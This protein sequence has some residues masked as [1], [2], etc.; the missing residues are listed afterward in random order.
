MK[1]P[2]RKKRKRGWLRMTAAALF[3]SL[4]FARTS[5]AGEPGWVQENDGWHYY[6]WDGTE[7]TG[8]LELGGLYYFLSDNGVCLTDAMTPD[9]Y[10]VDGNGAW[11]QREKSIL[12][13]RMTAPEQ[14]CPADVPLNEGGAAASL[15]GLIRRSFGGARLLRVSDTAIEYVSAGGADGQTKSG[16]EMVLAGLYREA[17]NGRYRLDLRMSLDAGAS[18][19]KT[20][21][22]FDYGVFQA[23][24]YQFSSSPEVLGAAVCSAWNGD[25]QWNINRQSPAEA[26]DSQVLYAAGDGFGR[27]YITPRSVQ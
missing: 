25:N 19:K 1:A 26:G 4:A 23:L 24:L 3:L 20:A 14:F 9:G 21:A 13:V 18:G 12:G 8:W 11:Y 10:Y 6:L 15:S 27:F 17:Q 22:A 2:E 16:E 7:K 5:L